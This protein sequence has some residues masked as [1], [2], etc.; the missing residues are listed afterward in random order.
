MHQHELDCCV[1]VSDC[2]EILDE[3]EDWIWTL[4]NVDS[5][6]SCSLTE[7]YRGVVRSAFGPEIL[8]GEWMVLP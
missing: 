1:D 6:G 4:V 2:C 5:R 3:F 7:N 8:V